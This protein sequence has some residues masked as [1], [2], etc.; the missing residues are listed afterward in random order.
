VTH[1]FDRRQ[2]LTH[3]AIAAGGVA[4]MG[5][6]G[7]SVLAGPA[8]AITKGGT[9]KVGVSSQQ[10]LPFSPD[11]GRMDTTG[12]MYARAVYD[13]LCVVSADGKTVHPY[14]AQSV[15]HNSTYTQ[16][17]VVI[18]PGIKFH[19]GTKCDGDAVYAN[20]KANYNSLLT[21]PSLK[22]L[23]KSFSH[24]AGSNTI[25][26]N[27]KNRWTS[28]P[29]TLAEQQIG[30]IAAPSTL[31]LGYRGNP[32]GTGPF[33]CANWAPDSTLYLDRNPNY[34][35]KGLPY[36]DHLEFHPI[37][38][39]QTRWNE[40]QGG[41]LD[42]IHTGDGGT[43]RNR[44]PGGFATQLDTTGKLAYS[45]SSNCVM[46]NLKKAPFTDLN[47]RKACAAAIDRSTFARISS[48]S[49]SSPVD[50]IY[51]PNSPYYVKPAY[52]AFSLTAAKSYLSKSSMKGSARNFTL[53][54]VN[55]PAV[56]NAA[57][58]VQTFLAKLNINVTPN[59][60]TQDVLIGDAIGGKFQATLWSQF[61]GVS[62]DT[63]YPWFSTKTGLN[64]AN[65]LDPKIESAMITGM[66]ATTS[67]ARVKAWAFVN[68]QLARDVPYLWLDRAIWGFAA[69]N[70][71]QSWKT[72]TD[73]VGNPILQPNQGV[74]FF[75]Q[76]WIS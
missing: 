20:F 9:L 40:L 41:T 18:R 39:D 58:L 24:T 74:L 23:I 63:N 44:F 47:F 42:L 21:G 12:F 31:G 76:T 19:D 15:T 73:S 30:F 37:P 51:L 46:L 57:T 72:F 69:K 55:S 54:Y 8:G 27:T 68:D 48:S 36:L 26:V 53:N 43:I 29:Y 13:P 59:P 50:G 67:S 70:T 65:N 25:V 34:W 28:F 71:V 3:S 33:V 16:W 52:P 60:M 61:G 45:P 32:I 38:D 10:K 35:R 2:F 56:A 14:L 49:E 17:T 75:T 6:M 66:A 22:A 64:F 62:P 1:T 5:A 11:W 4:A 7:E